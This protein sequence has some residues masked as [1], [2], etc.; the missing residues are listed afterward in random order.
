MIILTNVMKLKDCSTEG[1]KLKRCLHDT[2]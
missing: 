1:H 2:C